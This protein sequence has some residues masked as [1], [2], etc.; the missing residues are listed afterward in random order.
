[1]GITKHNYLRFL[2]ILSIVET[3]ITLPLI[4]QQLYP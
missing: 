2:K 1:V 3:L 4:V